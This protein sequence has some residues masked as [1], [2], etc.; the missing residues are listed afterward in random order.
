MVKYS[1]SC[2]PRRVCPPNKFKFISSC[3]SWG[4][5]LAIMGLS[6]LIIVCILI[7]IKPK[8]LPYG[9]KS[10]DLIEERRKYN[11][12]TSRNNNRN[13]R[14]D[15][16]NINFNIKKRNE[17]DFDAEESTFSGPDSIERVGEDFEPNDIYASPNDGTGTGV[18]QR[19]KYDINLNIRDRDAYYQNPNVISYGNY[20]AEKNIERIVN[21]LLPPERSYENT[22]GIPINMP[23]RGPNLSYQQI[24]HLYKDEITDSSKQIGNN[25]E[26]TILPLFSRP[27]F[28]GSNRWNYYTSSDKFQS[29]KLPIS[30]DGRKCTDDLGCKELMNGDVVNIPSYNGQFKVEIYDY[31]KPRYIPF[32]Y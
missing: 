20:Q 10:G 18:S 5:T 7:M 4:T 13:D 23:S 8:K 1:A 2:P 26:T 32:V 9:V 29:V 19:I 24:G 22:Y 15:R 11:N 12:N 6:A 31:D 27:T 17:T 28:N 3:V 21:P 30:I 25:S 14:N 16:N